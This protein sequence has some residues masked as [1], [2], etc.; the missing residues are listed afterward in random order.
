[1]S[2]PPIRIVHLGLGA[3]HRAHQAF[4]TARAVDAH[5]W[6][7]AAFTGRSRRL[8]DA[9][10]AQGGVYTL[11]ERA[12]DGDRSQ[13]IG[14]IVET[15]DGACVERLIE[16]LSDPDV[17]IVTLTITEAGYRLS[18]DGSVD[19]RDAVVRKDLDELR[20]A[21]GGRGLFTCEPQ[22]ALTRLLLGLEAR[23]RAG[24]G[25]IAVVSCDNLPDNGHVTARAL[26]ML[27]TLV[28][29]DLARWIGE[30]VSFVTT[31]VDRI[32]PSFEGT[33]TATIA[34]REWI[35]AVPVVT[36]PFSDWVLAGDFPA[37][38]PQWETAG[39]RFVDA[40]EPW[41][42]R[43]LWLLNGAHSILAYR[44]MLAGCATVVEAIAEPS[45]RHAVDAFW[46][47]AAD[48][49]PEAVETVDY[50]AELI[51]RFENSRIVHELQQIAAH[52]NVKARVRFAAVAE[53][54]LARGSNAD[55]SLF[56][57]SSWIAWLLAGHA[58]PK[59]QSEGVAAAVAAEDPVRALVSLLSATL[60]H[61]SEA[62]QRIR[63]GCEN[64]ATQAF[65]HAQ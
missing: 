35:D 61:D 43:K 21:W 28:D 23:R 32:T 29:A 54:S 36:E 34:G 24:A 26:D 50:R 41:E 16:L 17:A 4:Y 33:H 48:L 5:E 37:G 55:A 47:E 7:I 62:M 25:P 19:L 3:F 39:A 56:A 12:A 1:M 44:G 38:R 22:A 9:L 10:S 57:I 64:L 11:I 65:E 53:R 52:G 27:A 6:G 58:A 8:A 2:T 14:S 42:I 13:L 20:E 31:S 18:A 49:M 40:I 60:V 30:R 63:M 51:A 15:N 45:C 46:R 59:S